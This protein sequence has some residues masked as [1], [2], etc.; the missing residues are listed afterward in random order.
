MASTFECDCGLTIHHCSYL[1][2]MKSKR[3]EHMFRLQLV[4]RDLQG[5]NQL[6][7]QKIEKIKKKEK[8]ITFN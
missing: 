3:H 5:K 2:H 6:L 4:I 1:Y 7:E 8:E